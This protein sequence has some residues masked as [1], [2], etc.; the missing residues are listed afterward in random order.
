[1]FLT[2]C[3]RDVCQ[4][5]DNAGW[6]KLATQSRVYLATTQCDLQLT[7]KVHPGV[8]PHQ[9]IKPFMMDNLFHSDWEIHGSFSSHYP[10]TLSLWRWDAILLGRPLF[11]VNTAT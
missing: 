5:Y 9:I 1:M 3:F 8:P 4:M 7:D 11:M 2:N 10:S 6:D